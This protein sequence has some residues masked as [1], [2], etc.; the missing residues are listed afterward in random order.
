MEKAKAF[1]HS[2]LGLEIISY[3]PQK[4]I[5]LRAGHSVLLCFNPEDS[6][7]KQ[8]PPPHYA[9]GRQHFAFEVDQKDYTNTKNEIK[10]LGI[11]IIEEITWKNG[12]ESFYF[13]DPEGNV[14]EVVPEGVWD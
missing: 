8:S 9:S 11:K 13:N 3:L 7:L 10:Q 6:K 5:F 14:L 1:Y 12:M 2:T 4:H